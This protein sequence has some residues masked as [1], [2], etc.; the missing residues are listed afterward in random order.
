RA[1]EDAAR[2][3]QL[4]EAR[5]AAGSSESADD[6]LVEIE[7]AAETPAGQAWVRELA[8]M[9]LAWAERRGYEKASI[10]EGFEPTRVV[11]R[12]SGPGVLGYL[13][14]ECGLHR[15]IEDEARVAAYV[16]PRS[17]PHSEPP[18]EIVA[19]R[20]YRRKPGLF[21]ERVGAEVSARDESTGRAVT[22]HGAGSLG[23]LRAV[24][25]ALLSPVS[26]ASVEVRRYFVGRAPHVED[27]RTGAR[28]PRIKDVLRGE[29]E[30]FI[31]AWV[32]RTSGAA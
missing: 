8:A 30:I 7:A 27:P 17:W 6:A 32:A 14:G 19:A 29:L 4:L 22:L 21:L 11:L 13:A 10:A 24:T 31:A 12:I 26:L 9:Y 23:D 25:S 20:E 16:R 5:A 1:V 28:T 18:A 2:E 15:R 3:V